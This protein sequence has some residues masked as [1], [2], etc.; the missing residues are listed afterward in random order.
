M[1][2]TT[3]TLRLAEILPASIS[4]DENIQNATAA[5]QPHL[6]DVTAAIAQ[7]EILPRIDELPESILRMLAW[8]NGIYSTEWQL[9]KNVESK[10]QLVKDSFELNKR[11]GTRWAVERVFEVLEIP[12]ELSEW[13]EYDGDPYTFRINVL[14]VG[15][16]GITGEQIKLIKKLVN[17]YKPLRSHNESIN[18]LLSTLRGTSAYVGCA[19]IMKGEMLLYPQPLAENIVLTAQMPIGV[20]GQASINLTSGE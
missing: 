8:E 2:E 16:D 15:E 10:R 13:F 14:D 5:I 20:H 18:V 1:A 6:D 17:E 19:L 4:S 3:Q 12:A 7:I 11:R 9:A